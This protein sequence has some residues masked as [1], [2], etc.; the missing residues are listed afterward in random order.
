MKAIYRIRIKGAF[1]LSAI[2]WFGGITILPQEQGETML[3]GEFPDQSALRGLLEQLWNL[4][5]TVLSIEQIE[6]G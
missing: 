4:N 3:V 5:Y 1:S 6:K 2:E